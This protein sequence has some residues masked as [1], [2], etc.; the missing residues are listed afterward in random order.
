MTD[1][2]DSLLPYPSKA[3]LREAFVGKKLQDVATPAAIVDQAVVRRN[4]DQ[5][6][7]AVEALQV[8]F[9][10]HVKT[11]KVTDYLSNPISLSSCIIV[12]QLCSWCNGSSASRYLRHSIEH[13]DCP[14][15]AF[16]SVG[17]IWFK[18]SF[19]VVQGLP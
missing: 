19:T 11:H 2:V 5:M 8:D 9:R 6:L 16:E 17:P 7:M 3:Q 14:R 18:F 15:S 12:Y 10:P 1:S 13:L 4:C